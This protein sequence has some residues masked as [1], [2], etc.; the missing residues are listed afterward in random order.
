MAA[1]TIEPDRAYS[2][3]LKD[4]RWQKRRLEIMERDRWKCAFCGDKKTTLHV[5]HIKYERDRSPWAYDDLELI[6]LCEQCHRAVHSK[7]PDVMRLVYM[8]LWF[9]VQLQHENELHKKAQSWEI[10]AIMRSNGLDEISYL[11][12]D[13]QFETAERQHL[14]E[15]REVVFRLEKRQTNARK[16]G[17]WSRISDKPVISPLRRT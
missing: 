6:T 16:K 12:D 2:E 13:L 1:I 8:M 10:A 11:E 17:F 5:H 4:P 7:H 9:W 3:T 15:L 14:A